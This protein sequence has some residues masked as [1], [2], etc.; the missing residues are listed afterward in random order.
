MLDSS[1]ELLGNASATVVVRLRNICSAEPPSTAQ[2]Q[3]LHRHLARFLFFRVCLRTLHLGGVMVFGDGTD[4]SWLWPLVVYFLCFLALMWQRGFTQA[5]LPPV[6]F[7]L[8]ERSRNMYH[9]DSLCC[10]YEPVSPGLYK[11]SYVLRNK[12][13]IEFSCFLVLLKWEL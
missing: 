10:K 11:K 13:M 3:N 7:R 12:W 5:T 9:T 1:I 4:P 8:S 2:I 6:S